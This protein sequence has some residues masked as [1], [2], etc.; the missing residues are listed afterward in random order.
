VSEELQRA[1]R[2]YKTFHQFE[3]SDIGEFH[4][5]FLIPRVGVQVGY[6]QQMLY[7]SDKLNPET[8][9]DEGCIDY[10]HD[11][12]PNVRALRFGRGARGQSTLVPPWLRASKEF[13]LLGACLGFCYADADEG[14]VYAEA[15]EPYPDWYTSR[16]GRALLVVTERRCLE[17]LFFGGRL[18]VGARGVVD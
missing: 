10:I 18:R 1:E 6:A 4:P 5:S 16:C 14:V 7:R 3:P 15:V 2:L 12:G 13:V 11:H 9:A 8:G 17:A